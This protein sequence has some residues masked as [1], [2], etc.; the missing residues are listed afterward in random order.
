[1]RIGV[2]THQMSGIN[3]F[4]AHVRMPVDEIA[5]GEEGC[6]D[7][8]FIEDADYS[9]RLFTGAVIKCQINAKIRAVFVGL[10]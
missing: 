2:T 5:D 4:N 9:L 1:M 3:H 7:P 10:R 6:L 8:I